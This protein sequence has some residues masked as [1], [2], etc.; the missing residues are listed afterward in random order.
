MSNIITQGDVLHLGLEGDSKLKF[1]IDGVPRFTPETGINAEIGSVTESFEGMNLTNRLQCNQIE[2]ITPQTL[3]IATTATS[4]D[5]LISEDAKNTLV[6][7]NLKL[8]DGVES[9]GFTSPAGLTNTTVWTLPSQDGTYGQALKTS[10]IGNGSILAFEDPTHLFVTKSS[11]QFMSY[12][13]HNKVTNWDSIINQHKITWDATTGDM[14]IPYT[15]T[16]NVGY[17]VT[18]WDGR[19]RGG[20]QAYITKNAPVSFDPSNTRRYAHTA[21]VQDDYTALNQSLTAS[22]LIPCV[23]GDTIQLRC[24]HLT[25]D[26]GAN[27]GNWIPQNL[28]S[29]RRIEFWCVRLE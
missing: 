2:C 16:Y 10:G 21:V 19:V 4:N 11:W 5:I 26:P 3:N 8:T 25:G 22:T 20:R 9:L 28:N 6:R 29:D 27:Q 23:A 14:T 15:G 7:G 1:I 18:W 13:S 24:R 12:G 17:K